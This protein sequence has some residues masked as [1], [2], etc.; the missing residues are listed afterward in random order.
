MKQ[1]YQ[2]RGM[3]CPN[4]EKRIMTALGKMD[5]VKA[6]RVDY[7]SGRA[8]IESKKPLDR[9][10]LQ[11]ALQ[12]LGYE[13]S[14]GSDEL[15]RAASLLVIILGLTVILDRVGLLNRLVPRQLGTSGMSYGLFFVTGLLTS[16]HCVA[17]CGGINLSQSLPGRGK[18]SAL[19]YNAGRVVSYTLVGALLGAAGYLLG[20][21]FVVSPLLQGAVK[22]LAG[23]FMLLA[24]INLLGLF[25][26]LR[27]L[28]I[29]L[30]R[31]R[32]SSR[33]PFVIGLLNG[34]MPCGPLQAMQL[35]ALG[36]GN[37]LNGALS[38]L[39]FSL[40]TVPL[41]LG[42][43]GLVAL[44]GQRFARTVKLAGAVLV[45]VFGVAM[46]S[47]GAALFGMIDSF[48]LWA[49]LLSLSLLGLITL[50]PGGK[51][52]RRGLSI[53]VLTA[54]VLTLILHGTQAARKADGSV[55][56]R[57]GVQLVYSTLE[58][59]SYPD[60]TVQAGLPV[61]WTISAEEKSINGCNATM[62]IPGLDL[63]LSFLPGENVLEFIPETAG[64]IPYSCWMGMIRGTITVTD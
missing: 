6:V 42:L 44:L 34:L 12:N 64:K 48:R 11:S 37:P 33:L 47:Q 23:A 59:G 39:F 17:M 28:R 22:L 29:P 2:I 56:I 40:G 62:V 63:S 13:L 4:C 20:G 16:V 38:M 36:T 55:R 9:E 25:P 1:S 18:W 31:L 3:Y 50:A 15:T 43:G 58:A 46:L 35:A 41:M 54:L 26:A 27:R 52:L 14:N 21:S 60:I 10:Q 51:P 49:F 24:G 57:D 19:L 7:A 30:P 5:G 53:A 32:G 8:E 61:R 45:S